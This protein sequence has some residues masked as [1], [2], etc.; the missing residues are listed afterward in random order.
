MIARIWR[1]RTLAEHAEEYTRYMAATG[2]TQQR[3]T[4]GNVGSW[5][6]RRDDGNEAE[7]LVLS[8]W[9]SA[10]AVR[11]FAGATPERAVYYPE[12]ERFLLELEPGV[13]HYDIP[14]WEMAEG[15]HSPGRSE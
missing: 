10:A 5:I 7:F 14:V 4:P 15:K 11:A 8:L 12:D 2:V 1:G 13:L 6:L 3:G 9:E